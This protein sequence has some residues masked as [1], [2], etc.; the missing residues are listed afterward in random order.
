MLSKNSKMLIYFRILIFFINCLNIN[1]V[2]NKK[3]FVIHI[4]IRRTQRCSLKERDRNYFYSV[5][6]SKYVKIGHSKVPYNNDLSS[7]DFLD[8]LF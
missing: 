7:Y 4:Y 1:K 3:I 6:S 5:P 2:Y 8:S